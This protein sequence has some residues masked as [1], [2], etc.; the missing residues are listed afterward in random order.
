MSRRAAGWLGM[1]LFVSLLANVFLGSVLVAR[2]LIPDGND[3]Q[4]GRQSFSQSWL[5]MAET[6]P[7]PHRAEAVALW[8]QVRERRG[9]S[10]SEARQAV[11]A[12]LVTDPFDEAALQA[13]FAQMREAS[14]DRWAT[15]QAAMLATA[16]H[17]PLEQR[18][19]YVEQQQRRRAERAERKKRD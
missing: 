17:L 10:R 19:A 14:T 6:L 3:G 1:A 8:Q 2:M 16:R 5:E 12:A 13:A 11:Y 9:Q 4:R 18:R 7:E 15:Y